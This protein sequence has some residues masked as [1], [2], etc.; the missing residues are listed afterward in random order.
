MRTDNDPADGIPQEL[1]RVCPAC[2]GTG[3]LVLAIG[4]DGAQ[5]R[6]VDCALCLRA[7]ELSAARVNHLWRLAHEE[8]P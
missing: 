6:E 4:M 5:W 1:G 8:K 2:R 3:T 7:G